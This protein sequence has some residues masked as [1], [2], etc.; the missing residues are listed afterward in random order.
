PDVPEY[1]IRAWRVA[2]D[3]VSA[4]RFFHIIVK[5]F[6]TFL[7]GADDDIESMESEKKCGILGDLVAHY[8]PWE[9]QGRGTL[10]L[11]G[12]AWAANADLPNEFLKKI[13]STT[14]EGAAYRAAV[15]K[16]WQATFSEC[17][18][19]QPITDLSAKPYR[20]D[21]YTPFVDPEAKQDQSVASAVPPVAPEIPPLP[22]VPTN[23]FADLLLD[24]RND[25]WFPQDSTLPPAET[26]RRFD[27]EDVAQ[28][29]QEVPLLF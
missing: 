29:E 7:L 12:V 25:A 16:K 1:I 28:Q 27:L 11:H 8:C 13:K 19:H 3:P 14:A 21:K 4:A 9:A 15:L 17:V 18:P 26:W 5:A 2:R 10:H 6:L 24:L 20:Q 22:D 23:P